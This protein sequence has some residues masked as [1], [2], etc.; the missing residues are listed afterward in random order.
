MEFFLRRQN[1]VTVVALKGMLDA[2]TAPIF[3]KEM[4]V[5]IRDRTLRLVVDLKDVG[6]VDST[7]LGAL[8]SVL[9]QVHQEGGDVKLACLQERI[10][11]VFE[12]TRLDKVFDICTDPEEAKRRF[13]S[14]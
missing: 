7:G 11:A 10:R 1:G 8:I 14:K 5:L 3:K 12:L 6:F 9:R 2:S 4:A 13:G